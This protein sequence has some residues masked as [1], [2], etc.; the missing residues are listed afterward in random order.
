[1]NPSLREIREAL[2]AVDQWPLRDYI[3][4]EA[5]ERLGRRHGSWHETVRGKIR[6]VAPDDD[7]NY[8]IL[9]MMVLEK[10]GLGFTKGD[11][12]DLWI[13]HLPIGITFG[14][15]RQVLIK[16][17]M[18]TISNGDRD[19]FEEWV[20]LINPGNELCG[21]VIRADAYG[22]ACPGNPELASELA[23]RD[24]S[25]THR[26]TGIYG[27]MFI[28][29]AISLAQVTS[30]RMEI[31]E[32]ALQYIPRRSRF[33]EI[34]SDCLREVKEATDWLDGYERI[35]GKYSEF[36][37][38]RVY[39][40]IGTLMNTLKFAEDVW[41]GVCKQVSQGND[42]DSFGATA[43]SILGAYFGPE[44][45]DPKRLECFNDNI[46]TGMALFFESSLSKLADRM[47]RLPGLTR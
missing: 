30:D 16:A 36:C 21:A 11:L 44:G 9:G 37:H 22:Y 6:Y 40:E 46:H 34:I 24:S 1:V 31:F 8:T 12:R 7:I 38:C 28:A 47:G 41:D 5:L 39:Q 17:G 23:W 19:R 45:P 26:K 14:P 3:S 33:H 35:H 27:T 29:A 20:S 10:Y 18:A 25:F 42:T 2:E 4:E 13:E 15:E 32:R 43:G